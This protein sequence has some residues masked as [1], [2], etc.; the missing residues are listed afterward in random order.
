MA[1]MRNS[2]VLAVGIASAEFTSAMT[3]GQKYML[4]STTNCWFRVA[5]TGT[6]AVAGTANNVYLPADTPMILGTDSAAAGFISA[7]RAT[8]DGTANLVILES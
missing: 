3:T 2:Q 4:I 8:A 7:I 1:I 6:A 5:T